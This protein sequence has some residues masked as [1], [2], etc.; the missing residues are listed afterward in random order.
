MTEHDESP[1]GKA[2]DALWTRGVLPLALPILSAIAIGLW[3]TNLS[4]AFLAGGKNGALVIVIIVTVTIMVGAATMSAARQMGSAT[5]TVLVSTLIMLVLAGGFV[6]FTHAEE[7]QASGPSGYQEPKG[8]VTGPLEVDALPSLS[9]QAK[10]FTVTA[11]VI[12]IDYA[13]KG[14]THTLNFDTTD[15]NLKQF[16]L[17]V[18]TGKHSAKVDLKPG[19]YVIYCNIPGHRAAGMQATITAQ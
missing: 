15:P 14:G 4:R 10:E 1:E 9:F 2:D 8:P 3:V 13:D 19:K 12:Q 17:S 18:P 7:K 11:G 6:T 5:S 16:E